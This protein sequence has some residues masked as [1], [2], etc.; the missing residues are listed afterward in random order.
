M[1]QVVIKA[2]ICSS[3][4]AKNSSVAVAARA[5]IRLVAQLHTRGSGRIA[6]RW[7]AQAPAYV[8]AATLLHLAH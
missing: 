4:W 2:I 3:E 1:I 7:L 6:L 5:A 8:T